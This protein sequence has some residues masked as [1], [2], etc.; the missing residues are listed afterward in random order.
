MPE[1]Y[2][3]RQLRQTRS[4]IRPRISEHI[5]KMS[6]YQSKTTAENQKDPK[7]NE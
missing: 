5:I 2:R 1:A 6:R 3:R 4:E 7:V